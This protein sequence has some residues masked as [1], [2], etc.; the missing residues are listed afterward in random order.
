MRP[1]LKEN[2]TSLVFKDQFVNAV[3]ETCSVYTFLN[4]FILLR[5]EFQIG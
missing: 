5:I 4:G 3:K 2:T 1:Y